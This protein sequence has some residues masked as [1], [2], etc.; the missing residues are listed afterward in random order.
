MPLRN[1][2]IINSA[3]NPKIKQIAQLAKLRV[4][5]T[6]GLF[7]IE[8]MREI[9]LARD[10]GYVMQQVF[11]CPTIQSQ[12]P[13]AQFLAELPEDVPI[14]EIN[15]NLFA[16]IAYRDNVDGV[17]VLAQTRELPLDQLNLS[18][19]PLILVLESVEKP[20][21]LGAILR[22]ADAAGVDAVIVCDPQTDIYNPNVVRS[23][24]GCLFTCQIAVDSSANVQAFLKQHGIAA[25]A[26]TLAGAQWYHVTDF[27]IPCAIIL[28][29]E[30][31]GLSDFW[32]KSADAQ[33]TIPMLG[34]VDSLNVSTST[35]IL[36]YEAKR[37]RGF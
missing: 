28:G 7:V 5:R 36:V 12:Y 27:T 32:L 14:Y 15:D 20:G 37:Q 33:I 26:T 9:G 24:L 30:A 10:A 23:S 2:S 19:N 17:L 25:Y 31:Q 11:W 1:T 4:R 16:K 21:N 34:K 18:A 6:E 35:A 8:G 13:V 22:T 3:Q 29:T